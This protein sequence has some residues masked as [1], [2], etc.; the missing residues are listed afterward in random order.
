MGFQHALKTWGDGMSKSEIDEIFDEFDIDEITWSRPRRCSASLLPRRRK[1]R[2]R[3]R[4]LLSPRP[5]LLPQR[6][7]RARRRRRR[8]RRPPSKS[9][10]ASCDLIFSETGSKPVLTTGFEP[11]DY[12]YL[13]LTKYKRIRSEIQILFQSALYI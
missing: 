8:R 4:R 9:A 5:R 11:P 13:I 10:D 7:M 3:R 1:R 12:T 2:R 6:R